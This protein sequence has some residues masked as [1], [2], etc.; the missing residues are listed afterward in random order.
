[1]VV[2]WAAGLASD[3]LRVRMTWTQQIKHEAG[4]DH[5]D[6]CPPDPCHL[7]TESVVALEI[8]KALREKIEK[9]KHLHLWM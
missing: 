8:D 7:E 4:P 3:Y 9:E 2:I 1:M 5:P 6:Q